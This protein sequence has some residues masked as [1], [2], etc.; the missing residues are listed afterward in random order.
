M[1]FVDLAIDQILK[2]SVSASLI[3]TLAKAH[4]VVRWLQ[5]MKYL[6]EVLDRDGMQN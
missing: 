5:V 2:G 3:A 4:S 1:V 6:G